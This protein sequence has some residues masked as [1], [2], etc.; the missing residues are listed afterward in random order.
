MA[1][2]VIMPRQGQSVESCIIS[3]WFKNEGDEI[4]KGDML[5]SYETDKAAFECESEFEGILLKRLF[6]EGDEVPVLNMVA[7]IGNPGESIDQFRKDSE[8]PAREGIFI[9]DNKEKVDS[10]T[11]AVFTV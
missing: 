2:P 7:I 4:K 3:S 10:G 6:Q 1:N 5:F 9:A 8:F 11:P